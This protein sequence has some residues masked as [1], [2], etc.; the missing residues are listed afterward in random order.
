MIR[1]WYEVLFPRW[2]RWWPTRDWAWNANESKFYNEIF[3]H[4]AST[5]SKEQNVFHKFSPRSLEEQRDEKAFAHKKRKQSHCARGGNLHLEMITLFIRK[6]R[7][8]LRWKFIFEKMSREETLNDRKEIFFIM[9]EVKMELSCFPFLWCRLKKIQTL[10]CGL[11]EQL[12]AGGT[13]SGIGFIFVNNL[14]SQLKCVR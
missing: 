4:P 14:H 5:F 3:H 1:W 8:K 6:N 12:F 9:H 11:S 7:V 10:N 2:A 13:R